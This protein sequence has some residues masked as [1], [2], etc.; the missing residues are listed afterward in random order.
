VVCCDGLLLLCF[1]SLLLSF[2]RRNTGRLLVR[3][4]SI[5]FFSSLHVIPVNIFTLSTPSTEVP[6]ATDLDLEEPYSFFSSWLPS[7]CFFS[8]TP[9]VLQ[10]LYKEPPWISFVS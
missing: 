3:E 6:E 5:F 4:V 10:F 2:L 9:V 8:S 1:I 7:S